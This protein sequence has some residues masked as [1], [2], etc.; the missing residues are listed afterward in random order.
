MHFLCIFYLFKLVSKKLMTHLVFNLK[1]VYWYLI[2][3]EKTLKAIE[4][5]KYQ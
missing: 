5:V 4:N 1:F 2:F 3:M